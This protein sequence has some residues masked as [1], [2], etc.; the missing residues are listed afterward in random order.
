MLAAANL[1]GIEMT[2]FAE[3]KEIVLTSN[4]GT[5]F[6]VDIA[7][8]TLSG[9]VREIVSDESNISEEIP[10]P[11]VNAADLARVI[12]FCNHYVEEKMTPIEKVSDSL[13][14]TS[15]TFLILN[16]FVTAIVHNSL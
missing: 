8:A 15:V 13:H 10:V 6:Q 1:Q 5:T 12:E 7:A 3:S 4:D 16:M 11:N 14:F 9:F 2:E